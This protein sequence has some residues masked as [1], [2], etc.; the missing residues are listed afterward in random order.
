MNELFTTNGKTIPITAKMVWEAYLKVRQGGDAPGVDGMDWETLDT[1]RSKLLYKLWNRL[2]SGSYFPPAVR[3]QGICKSDGGVRYLSIPT[4]LDRVAQQVI[5]KVLEPMVEPHFHINSYAYREG[6]SMH[7]AVGRARV[8]NSEYRYVLEVD[9]RKYFDS[10]DHVLLEKAVKNYCVQKWVML[11]VKRW[12]K[13]PVQKQ[14]GQSE[15]TERGV[16]QGGGIS[17]LLANLFLHIVFDGWIKKMRPQVRF[18]R[19]ADDIIVHSNNLREAKEL[20]RMIQ[21]RFKQYGLELHSQKTQIVE[22]KDQQLAMQGKEVKRKEVLPNSYT[23][24]SFTFQPVYAKV[25][26]KLKLMT[27]PVPSRRS[28]KGIVQKLRDLNLHKRT[29]SI[30]VVANLVNP[31]VRGWIDYYCHFYHRS[32]DDIWW[33]INLRLIKW[34]EWNKRMSIGKAIRWLKQLQQLQP[35]LFKHWS[36]VRL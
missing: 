10:I 4:M 14:N 25:D 31:L 8:N 26:G 23:F 28:K 3:Q 29:G 21:R 6:K 30:Y 24:G 19:Y 32:L 9:I 12:L 17:P 1:N 2:S 16:S 15:R 18:E 11:Y 5:C 33:L 36:L 7:D 13:A 20:L 22:M 34:C 27:L 35:T